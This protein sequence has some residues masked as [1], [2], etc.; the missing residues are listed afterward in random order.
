MS[1]T[2][3]QRGAKCIRGH[4]LRSPNLAGAGKCLACS[5]AKHRN[6]RNPTLVLD[7]I[8]D[9]LYEEITKGQEATHDA[10]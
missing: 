4:V 10:A 3:P 5:V 2:N 9:Q 7:D 8:A 1:D 6:R